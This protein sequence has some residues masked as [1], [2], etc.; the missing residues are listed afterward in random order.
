MSPAKQ[1]GYTSSVSSKCW[2]SYPEQ[3]VQFCYWEN[4]GNLTQGQICVCTF[5][6]DNLV[7]V[8]LDL[9][10]SP[11]LLLS[12]SSSSPAGCSS[13]VGFRGC[14]A[15]RCSPNYVLPLL[16]ST[17]PPDQSLCSTYSPSSTPAFTD[18]CRRQ[19]NFSW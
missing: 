7:Q 11:A 3:N 14:C 9:L 2:F 1:A 15:L 17:P 13:V 10:N 4:H 12:S 18:F 19:S 8:C 5:Q 6:P 16:S